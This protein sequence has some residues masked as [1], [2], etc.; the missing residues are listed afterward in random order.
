MNPMPTPND[1]PDG[2]YGE[3]QPTTTPAPDPMQ[4]LESLL[5]EY[6]DEVMNAT[7]RTGIY[8][9]GAARDAIRTHVRKLA[10]QETRWLNIARGCH[11]YGGGY[12][13][14][15]QA[16]IF[17]HGIQTVINSLEAAA[18]PGND[19]QVNALERIGR[20]AAQEVAS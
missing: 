6:R 11:D 8:N 17:H 5:D 20:N 14:P 4:A 3:A 16:E 1:P 15:A 18:K 7:L 13:E 2:L 19:T 9:V 10:N 12:R